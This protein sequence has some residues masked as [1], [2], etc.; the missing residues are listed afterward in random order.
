M[1]QLLYPV[2]NKWSFYVPA[3][4]IKTKQDQTDFRFGFKFRQTFIYFIFDIPLAMVI[5]QEE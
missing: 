5:D 4:Q 1:R 3:N 2:Y